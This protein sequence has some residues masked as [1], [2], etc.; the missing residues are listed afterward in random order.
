MLRRHH[1]SKLYFSKMKCTVRVTSSLMPPACP[2]AEARSGEGVVVREQ[3]HGLQGR[4][5]GLLVTGVLDELVSDAV[6]VY[7]HHAAGHEAG[8]SRG[9][10]SPG[11][12][13]Q[14]VVLHVVEVDLAAVDPRFVI[15]L[16]LLVQEAF[17]VRPALP[18]SEV[19]GGHADAVGIGHLDD[20]VCSFEKRVVHPWVS[21]HQ[22]VD[23]CRAR[24]ERAGHDGYVTD[25]DVSPERGARPDSQ[26]PLGT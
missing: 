3:H 10:T 5:D 6:A 12:V 25:V 18:T 19:V 23:V 2:L 8:A 22:P 1:I 20:L 4:L 17:C 13:E 21:I 9:A 11:P 24:R 7:R 14:R 16:V 15:E 26:V